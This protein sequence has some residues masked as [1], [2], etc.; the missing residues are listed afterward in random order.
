MHCVREVT[1]GL[2]W[3][4]A[5]DHTT[6]LFE[7]IHPI[8]DGV[9]Y[10][11][12]VLLDGSKTVLFDSVDWSQCRQMIENLTY[13][14]DGR[15]LDY[16]V[17]NH[18]EPDHCAS[19]EY[20]LQ[21]YPDCKIISTEKGFMLMRQFGFA[22]DS[23]EQIEVHEGDTFTVDQH[24]LTFV[25]APMVHWPEPMVTLDLTNGVLFSADAFGA[26]IANDGKLWNDDVNWDRDY[27]D[28]GRRYFC[29][30]VGRYGPH[31]QLL[32]GKA[33]TVIDKIKIICPLHGLL[34]HSDIG[35][36]LDKYNHWSSYTPEEQGVLIAY[37]S[38]YGNTESAVQA[39]ASEI[40]K[41]GV[42]NV[43]VRN[44]SEVHASYLVG[45][46]FKLS[47]IVLA[48][49]TYN[50]NIYP[51]MQNFLDELR[52]LNMQNRTVAIV[53][54]GSWACEVGDLM[55]RYVEDNMKDMNVLNER[56]TIASSM[57]ESGAKELDALADAI[58]EATK[59]ASTDCATRFA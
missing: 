57:K 43:R 5:N 14:L 36:I 37:A 35:Y 22:V 11:N 26:F 8:P 10:N 1:D 49:P 29:N 45:D 34:W 12:Y 6:H 13:V 56:V 52:M 19:L 31:V 39:L 50:L 48:S 2:Y 16:V 46:A 27:L 3:I 41:R 18:V 17:V 44:V 53:E 40:C 23:H 32:L 21:L 15:T 20:V 42:T 38:M 59:K 58:V 33:A 24:V 55:Q 4:G 30:I 25:E 9:S 28:E 47:T 54:N 51:P 7:A